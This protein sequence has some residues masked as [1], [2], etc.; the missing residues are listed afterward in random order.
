M[1]RCFSAVK[2][3]VT[4]KHRG[5]ARSAGERALPSAGREARGLI[6][7]IAFLMSDDSPF[8]NGPTLVV[9]SGSAFN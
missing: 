8:I 4:E 2:P 6:G 3:L 5:D 1:L 9:D 7:T